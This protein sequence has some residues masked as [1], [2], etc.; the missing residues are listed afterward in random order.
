VTLRWQLTTADPD[1]ADPDPA[2]AG[3]DDVEAD[4][5][6]RDGPAAP[7]LAISEAEG[8]WLALPHALADPEAR[9]ALLRDIVLRALI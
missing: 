5:R 4:G 9:R 6:P 7:D 2:D 3:G 1:P 8:D